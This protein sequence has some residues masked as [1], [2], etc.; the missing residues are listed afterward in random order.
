MSTI[1]ASELVNVTPSVLS[2]GGTALDVVGLML[3]D[4]ARS[5]VG[6]VLQFAD[7][8]SV[9][10]Y[11]GASSTLARK[12]GKYFAGF[13]G[14]NKI[15]ALLLV[16]QF[17][18]AET[19]AYLR[20]GAVSALTLAQLQAI[21]G[22][23]LIT[24]DGYSRNGGTVNLSSAVSF[25]AAAAL[26]QTALNS[27]PITIN[28]FTGVLSGTT[29][30]V[31]SPSGSPIGIGQTVVGAGVTAATTITA[32]GTGTGG[33]GTYVVNNS[34]SVG[35]ESMTTQPTPVAA[36]YDSVQGAFVV[37]SGISGAASTAAFA[38]GTAAAAVKLTS[39]TGAV[40]SQ[41]AAAQATTANAAAFMNA[42]IAVN[43]NWVTFLCTFDPDA[44]SGSAVKQALCAWKNTQNNRFAYVC[45]DTDLS[46]TV[47][48]PAAS[49]L[50]QILAANGD[51]GT[52]LIWQPDYDQDKDAF[53]CGAAAAI[54]FS[55]TAGRIS[56]AYKS[57][58]GLAADVSNATIAVNLGGNPQTSDRGNG[59]NFYG[60]YSTAGAAVVP[61]I[62]FQRGFVTGP[63]KWLDSYVN[64]VQLN[65][66]LQNALL[67]LQRNAKSIPYS[68]SG[69]ALIE[70]AL[71]DPIAAGLNFGS[72][73]PAAISASQ[74]A[75]VNGAAGAN[76]APT[77]QTQGYYLQIKQAPA[78]TR[79]AR[80]TPPCT[81]WY[82]D[83]GS[84]QAINLASVALQ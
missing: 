50:G 46:P 72:F 1:P 23:L 13:T 81:F 12:G 66:S 22:T 54:D 61:Q 84:V 37:T 44:G 83:Q 30:T 36:T 59:Y 60:A 70:S 40:L 35:S 38:T 19:A 21:S 6:Q 29:L 77:L 58:A 32:L 31:T 56:F 7:A 75:Q 43:S 71:A 10:A 2:A 11:F 63:F 24:M 57:Q 16:S 39:A 47:S 41:G 68:I 4:D 49:S 52:G 51:S 80:T 53:V 20:G 78:A 64:Q 34:Q 26:I 65:S 76:V 45:V 55:Q 62:W 25:S 15:P 5:P 73:G 67:N 48:V 8:P 3:T 9:S 18:P 82:V 17:N 28:T 27:A 74:A 42:L 69:A 79:A 33:A 14:E